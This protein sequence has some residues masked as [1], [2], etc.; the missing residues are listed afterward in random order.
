MTHVL[1]LLMLLPTLLAQPAIALDTEVQQHNC[2]YDV[3]ATRYEQTGWLEIGCA[4]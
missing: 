3:E 4:A 1:A 2:Y